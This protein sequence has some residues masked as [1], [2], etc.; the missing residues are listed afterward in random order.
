MSDTGN[1]VIENDSV[2]ARRE[3][4]AD[5]QYGGYANA[6]EL[7]RGHYASV[8][9]E[10]RAALRKKVNE[11]ATKEARLDNVGDDIEV[12]KGGT[13]VDWAIRGDR[14]ENQVIS[15]VW[16][17]EIGVW[18]R[19]VQGLT[20]KYRPPV[21]TDADR[22]V[23]ENAL[24]DRQ[25]REAAVAG[26]A[27]IETRVAQV[28]A[29]LAAE[30]EKNL[31]DLRQEMN[32]RIAALSKDKETADDTTSESGAEHQPD[33][34]EDGEPD[35]TETPA[36]DGELKWPREHAKLDKL[37]KDAGLKKADLPSDWDDLNGAEKVTFLQSK[38]VKPEAEG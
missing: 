3:L 25:V 10:V 21:E 16:E 8:S 13:L 2:A 1:A 7:I 5:G 38:G 30:H 36:G 28:R 15:F 37:A 4:R 18:H 26:Q 19:G 14:E 17:D 35:S 23:R 27:D 32:D 22:A 24:G 33:S 29:E 31:A 12:P 34:N 6:E 9:P 11:E 20:D